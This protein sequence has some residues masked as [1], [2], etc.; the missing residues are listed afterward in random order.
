MNH[1]HIDGLSSREVIE[2]QHKYGENALPEA[3]RKTPFQHFFSQFSSPLILILIIAGVITYFL[4]DYKDTVVIL[5][6]VFINTLLGFYQEMKAEGALHALKNMISPK[7]RVIR[8]AKEI[9]IDVKDLV[10]GDHVIIHDGD[11][12]PADGTCFDAQSLS[13]NESHLTGESLAVTKKL[14]DTLYMGSHVLGGRGILVVV[15]T[16]SSTKI[17]EIAR[18]IAGLEDTK[19][20]LQIRLDALARYIGLGVIVISSIVFAIGLSYGTSFEEMF[21]TSVA[22][23]VASVPEGMAISLTVI[24]A[25]GMQRILKRKALVRRLVA[26][27]TLGSVT[28]V[29]TD[30]TGTLT[31]GIMR[32]THEDLIHKSQALSA[33]VYANNLDD[34]LEIAL[35]EWAEKAG[36]DPQKM[37]DTHV[38][39]KEKPFDSISKYMSVQIAGT[40]YI[41]GAPDVL[42]T[43]CNLEAGAEERYK[44]Y[45]D[46]LASQGKRLIAFATRTQGSKKAEWAGVV[47]MTDPLREE[48]PSVLE[49]CKRAGMRVIMITGDYAGTA[50]A[51]WKSMYPHSKVDPE[52]VEGIHLNSLSIDQLKEKILHTDIFARV[53]PEHKLL[54]VISL[55]E[56]GEVVALIG[57][58]VNDAPAI[59][60]AD[61]GIVVGT[62]SDVSKEVAD[63]VLLDSNF[64]TIVAAIEE[65]RSIFENMRKVLL[66]LLSDSFT[67]IILVVG[68]LILGLPLPLT[69]AQILWINIVT[70]GVP[71]M[72]LSFD[73]KE[74]GLLNRPP[75]SSKTALISKQLVALIATISVVTGLLALGLFVWYSRITSI[76]VARTITFTAVS[77]GT[78]AY[79]FSLHSLYSPL[80]LT[81]F[82]SNI[83]L[84]MAAIVGIA[85]QAVPLFMPYMKDLFHTQPIRL[86]DWGIIMIEILLV[87]VI[88]EMAKVVFRRLDTYHR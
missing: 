28:V 77:L 37:I 30:K 17:G 54:I 18:Q 34:P 83:W 24:L 62:A 8:D 72:A 21:A 32:V 86:L 39:E 10:P 59:K 26:A 45:I 64:K 15:S 87:L 38:R 3:K 35:W 75:I 76:E 25:I 73:K 31:E 52:I 19:T 80:S 27:E 5:L 36:K 79:V 23:A 7:A 69:A 6:A 2:L 65:G 67:Q 84:L 71:A 47:A 22:I 55:Q 1:N 61:I 48:I 68:A 9:T 49:S 82:T 81:S 41:K 57:D 74:K 60:K 33:A 85:M 40:E 44:K 56:A 29:A 43:M 16:G 46:D 14:E 66:Y 42:L 58:G 12:I 4:K 51:I 78:I 88:I 50:K 13:V 70:D 20:P 53:T 63:M 11:V